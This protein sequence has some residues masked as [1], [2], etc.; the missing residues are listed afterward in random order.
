MCIR[1]RSRA[2][3]EANVASFFIIFGVYLF[4]KAV[5]VKS[6]ILFFSVLSFVLSLYTFNTARV[7]TPLLA[8]LLIIVFY[9]S[10]WQMR[11][12][13]VVCIGVGFILT[14]PYI[15]FVMTPQAKLRYREVNIFSD[16]RLVTQS[17]T[18]MN[19]DKEIMGR[20]YIPFW[21]RVVHNRRIFYIKAYLKHY[22]DHFNPDFLF[23]KGDGNP[24]FSTQDVGQLYLWSLPFL[25]I[26]LFYL[27]RQRNGY[28]YLVIVWLLIGILPAAVAR[29]TPHALRIESTLPAW[30]I[31]ISYGVVYTFYTLEKKMKNHKKIFYILT[32]FFVFTYMSNVIYYVH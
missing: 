16:I 7:V 5:R 13:V 6:Y 32:M 2:A 10:L 26:G 30:Q 31:M 17:N 25:V 4:L 27:I 14:I 8:V 29:E 15:Q 1:D 18:Y 12:I 24:K 19:Q 23:I 3:F 28:W 22:F 21:S 11:K 20:F 9:K